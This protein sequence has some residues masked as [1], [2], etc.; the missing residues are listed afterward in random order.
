MISPRSWDQP[1]TI[2][3]GNGPGQQL[4]G[5]GGWRRNYRSGNSSQEPASWHWWWCCHSPGCGVWESVKKQ[6]QVPPA[7]DMER[8]INFDSES[9]FKL[10]SSFFMSNKLFIWKDDLEGKQRQTLKCLALSSAGGYFM[11]FLKG[12]I[13]PWHARSLACMPGSPQHSLS[14]DWFLVLMAS[15]YL[16]KLIPKHAGGWMNKSALRARRPRA[17]I[18]CFWTCCAI[19]NCKSFPQADQALQLGHPYS[20]PVLGAQWWREQSEGSG[21]FQELWGEKSFSPH[22]HNLN[23]REQGCMKVPGKSPLPLFPHILHVLSSSEV[24]YEYLGCSDR[25]I[26]SYSCL[27]ADDSNI[28]QKTHFWGQV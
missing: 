24:I 7:P 20:I 4:R 17:D 21:C 14:K 3:A 5:Y 1:S 8:Y 10:T 2:Q 18:K 23:N 15:I 9:G 12:M 26:C 22:Q 28:L 13:A 11:H 19:R 16:K 6:R 27:R 25:Y